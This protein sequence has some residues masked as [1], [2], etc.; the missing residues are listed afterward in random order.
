MANTRATHGYS[1]D[2]IQENVI[3]VSTLMAKLPPATKIFAA[4][5]S[6]RLMQEKETWKLIKRVMEQA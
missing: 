1:K 6:A 4:P 3:I 2:K 5:M